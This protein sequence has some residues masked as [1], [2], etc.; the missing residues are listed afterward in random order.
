M[1]N[2]NMR[3]FRPDRWSASLPDFTYPSPMYATYLGPRLVGAV[4][5]ATSGIWA[6]ITRPVPPASEST[7]LDGTLKV[8]AK[9]G[10]ALTRLG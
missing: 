10:Q 5:R 7:A 1:K 2:I 3:K 4:N 8:V 6:H 9:V